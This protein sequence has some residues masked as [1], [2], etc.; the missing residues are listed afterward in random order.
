LERRLA[1]I[2]AADVVGYTRLMG[3]DEAGT[4][5]RLTELRQ[6]ILEPL[7]TENN[8]RIVKLMGDGFLVEFSSV[9][10]AVTCATTWQRKVSEHQTD[11]DAGSRL[12]FRIGVNLGDVIVEGGDIHGD[13]VNI[14]ARLEGLADPGGI[15]LSGDAY[16]QAKGKIEANFEDLGDQQLKN[17]AEPIRVYRVSTK[18]SVAPARS[19]SID[20]LPLPAKPSIAVLPFDN[21]SGDSEQGYLADGITEDLI[22]ALS[23]IRWFF[24]IARNSTFTYKGQA[25][26]VTQVAK[27]LGV[28]YV[29]E[30]SVRR[31]GNRVRITAQ[32]VDA[33]NGRHVWA[34]R[35]DRQIE[36]I[37]DLQ[38]EMTQTI[39]GAVEPELSAAERERA[40]RKSPESL[41]AWESYQRGLWFVWKFDADSH[42]QA[43]SFFKRA[44]DLDPGFAP[45]YAYLGFAYYHG[46]IM[47]WTEDAQQSLDNAMTAASKALSLDERD[48]LA[49]FAAGRVHMM[50]GQHD[51]SIASLK[52]A[53]ELNPS[54]A[55]AYFGL[56]MTLTLAGHL[57]EAKTALS[58]C[59]RLSPRDPVLWASTLILA[60]ACILSQEHEEAVDW[61]HKTIQ[62]PRAAGYWPHAVLAAALAHLGQM[63][64]AREALSAALEAKPDLSIAYLVKTLPTKKPDG[65]DLYL[66]GLRQ[67]GLPD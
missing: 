29:L 36:D 5:R 19:A 66:D 62:N 57:Q 13:G 20:A 11:W 33:T 31:A 43:L 54:F 60:M 45:A 38:D 59:M 18:S 7:I 3:E 32:L 41:D 22:T 52:T 44:T 17:V 30:G 49:Y 8:G 40:S 34:E 46:V 42:H 14:A 50:W 47:G 55:Q 63:D 15:C 61:A 35:Y 16:R 39:V 48:P 64:E 51:D 27:E 21:M 12:E 58:Q 67:A 53:I 4:L 56:G 37:F 23:K 10:N 6:D 65:L 1:A 26:D 28:R 9:V 2:L 25:V 24:V